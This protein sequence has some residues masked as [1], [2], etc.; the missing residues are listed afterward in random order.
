MLKKIYSTAWSGAAYVNPHERYLHQPRKSNLVLE[1]KWPFA[2]IEKTR[3]R[4]SNLKS[5]ETIT[6]R[7]EQPADQ[8][9]DPGKTRRQ[10]HL[11][12]HFPASGYVETS[13]LQRRPQLRARARRCGND[14]LAAIWQPASHRTPFVLLSYVT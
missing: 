14:P 5:R 9:A 12:I 10:E 1:R 3:K 8:A 13:K 4:R 2:P 11:R 6:T 7:Q